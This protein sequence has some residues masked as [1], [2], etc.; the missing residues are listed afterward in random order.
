[1]NK[2]KLIIVFSI[3]LLLFVNFSDSEVAAQLHPTYPPLPE[4][5]AALESDFKVN[6]KKID[7]AEWEEG[8]NFYYAFEPNIKNPMIGFI[9]YPGA[10]VDPVAYA[11][12]AH[13]IAKQGYLVLIVKMVDDLAIKSYTRADRIISDYP[14]I[15]KWI[16][17]GHSL[18][19]SMACAY[20]KEFTDKVQGVVLWASFPSETFRIDDKPLKA[21]SI[22]STK[23]GAVEEIKE[24][25][26]YLPSDTQWVAIEGGNHT[27][28]GYYWDGV[29][30]D[31]VQPLDNPA[32]ISREQQQR[33]IIKAT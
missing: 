27:Q 5:L 19:G 4:A 3:A 28:F 26:I 29:D 14:A 30:A 25:K 13:A 12:P 11:P 31:F 32:D 17:G 22:Y 33:Q 7:V 16:I 2:Q 10:L 15:K 24:N 6:V 23:D 8:S 9:I 20:A 1:M 21:I 18:G